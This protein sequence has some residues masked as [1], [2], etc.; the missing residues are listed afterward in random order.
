M[1]EEPAVSLLDILLKGGPV[2]Y[3]LA[4]LFLILTLLV[5]VYLLT[6]TRGA[7][8]TDRFMALAE[9]MMKKGDFLGLVAAC[10]RR[11]EAA[12]RVLGRV[13]DFTED[14]PGAAPEQIREIAQAEGTR[15]V[16]LLNQRVS[17]LA[18]IATLAP[19]LGLLGTVVGIIN[20]FGVLASEAPNTSSLLLAKGVA[21]AL[22]TTGAG[23]VIGIGAA[24]F[25]AYFRGKAQKIA[26]DF[27]T[28]VAYLAALHAQHRHFPRRPAD[29]MTD[30]LE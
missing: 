23:L 24:V 21:Q 28:G 27:E 18:D 8:I 26:S 10:S 17:Y 20:S 14:N 5:A 9:A 1:P 4:A 19:L 12:A 11:R 7:L 16:S 15:H 3:P 13:I 30:D 25:Y 2:M 22:V 6:I 29:R